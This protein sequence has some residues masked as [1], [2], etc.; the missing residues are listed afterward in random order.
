MGMIAIEMVHRGAKDDPV[1]PNTSSVKPTEL[2]KAYST[3]RL[4]ERARSGWAPAAPYRRGDG[5][6]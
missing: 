4:S 1:K 6:R 5:S 3:P 2:T